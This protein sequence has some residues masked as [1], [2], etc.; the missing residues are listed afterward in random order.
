MLEYWKDGMLEESK[1]IQAMRVC[2]FLMDSH[3]HSNIPVF[4]SSMFP[5]FHCCCDQREVVVGQ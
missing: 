5:S 4:P 2:Y 3:H 1:P